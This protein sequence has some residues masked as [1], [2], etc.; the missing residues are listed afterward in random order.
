MFHRYN[1][2]AIRRL[3]G[4]LMLTLLP[5]LL[6]AQDG[7]LA[8]AERRTGTRPLPDVLEEIRDHFEITFVYEPSV[9][10]GKQF[11]G[12]IPPREK[13]EHVLSHVLD[14]LGL[15]FKKINTRTY[16][17]FPKARARAAADV[18]LAQ[19]NAESSADIFLSPTTA[20]SAPDML[21]APA[22][23]IQV[24]GR[25]SDD[26]GNPLPG[27]NIL[28][29]GTAQGA[30]TDTDGR[31]SLAVPDGSAVLVITF[32]GYMSQE[33]T[34]GTQT[35]LNITLLPDVQQLNEVVVVGYGTQRRS[36]VTGA[37]TSVSSSEVAALPVAGVD[38]A[39]QGRVPGVQVTNNGSPGTT[40]SVRIR[41]IGSI[42]GSSQPLYVIDGFP[43]AGNLNNIDTKDIESVEVLK[44]AAASAIYGSRAANGVIIITTKSGARDNKV[45][46][47]VDAYYGVQKAWR[48]LDLLGTDD[49][50][51]YGTTL[52]TNAG[53]ELPKRFSALDEPV[54]AGASQ[55]YRQ[56]H[57]DWQDAMFRTAP[58]SQVQVSLSTGTEKSKLYSSVSRFQQEGI[59]LGTDF[60]RY[61]LRLNYET[62]I[63]NRFTFGENFSVSTATVQN[64]PE[65][66]AR[67][68]VQHLIRSVPYIPIHDPTLVGGFRAPSGNDGSDP[69][70]PVR[71]A[72]MDINKDN[73][74]NLIGRAY[75]DARIVDGLHYRFTAGLNYSVVRHTED[76]PIYSDSFNG[77]GTH[78]I[79]DNRTTTLSPYF[80]NQLTFD[81]VIGAHTLNVVAVAERQDNAIQVLNSS[82]QHA[83]NDIGQMDGTANP[84]VSGNLN[85]N[86]LLSF[87]GRV[88]Y[89]YKS[90]YL[91]SASLRRDGYS[92]FSPDNRW[93][94][95]P[96]VSVGWRLSEEDF[97][98]S[99]PSISELKVR[100]SYGS[101]GSIASV[102]SYEYQSFIS[103]NNAYPFN[104]AP[105]FGSYYER[106]SNPNLTWEKTNMINYGIDLG[107]FANAL[108]FSVE[109]FVRNT[110]DLL[111][112]VNATPSLGFTAPTKMNVAKMKNWGTEF[113]VGYAKAV[114]ELT[115]NIGANVGIVRNEVKS[116]NT[117]NAALFSGNNADFGGFN[118]TRTVAGRPIQE[119]YGYQTDGIFQSNEEIQAANALDGD[120][121]T[122]YQNNAAPGDIRF[123]D[124]NDD[125]VIDASDQKSLGNYMPDF[126]Y[127]INLSAN[128]RNF[129]LAIFI[130]GVQGNSIY[131]G[132]K[133]L[134]QGMLR[135]FGAGTAVNNAWTETNRNTD[136]PRAVSGDPNQNT[137]T[138][139]RFLEDG[140][141]LRMK[142]ISIGYTLPTTVAQDMTR[143][144][145]KKLRVYVSAQNLFTITDY[146]GYDPEIG[147]RYQ[148]TTG[149][150]LINGIDF[151]QFPSPRTVMA[152]VQLG[153]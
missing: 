105:T 77:R 11:S 139:D 104:N 66:G 95:F 64:Q 121:S 124:I 38:A 143:G 128:Y 72:S 35:N 24:T 84:A 114:G 129:D 65:S 47:D 103:S 147:N 125:G 40:P 122:K 137:R 127:G 100:A 91:L 71:I 98:K 42:T 80:S 140:S 54:Y 39:I 74:M 70:N 94:S 73:I 82:A 152:G 89:E 81:K 136:V 79:V 8:Q 148:N 93:G 28:L 88:N 138:S 123:K 26:A 14:P 116:L 112:D 34:V 99:V 75:I 7:M 102:G 62:R 60:D 110:D 61:S 25:V 133:V 48:Q 68:M 41:G 32:I 27:V 78:N 5:L 52:L 3:C 119:F 43:Q 97:L 57:T 29:K 134:E 31:F 86:V 63:S 118:I 44:D 130:Q 149:N 142:N 56:T 59:M 126:T 46:I 12:T 145:L 58:I 141:F 150:T 13:V 76:L 92:G 113:S 55:T 96:G 50:I 18:Q 109:Y 106:L 4:L 69:E 10:E 87:L 49:Y 1:Y 115:F 90:K 33:I 111:L 67:T 19:A 131:N 120:P 117:P 53:S 132:T 153:F 30:T 6:P 17:I 23:D 83:R 37:V 51:K 151:G 85:E 108:T 36:S 9:V 21:V 2:N 135:L 22:A 144:T 101:L 146:T 107:L 15:K 45:H 20:M 16:S